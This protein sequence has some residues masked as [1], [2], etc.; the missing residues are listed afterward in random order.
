[1]ADVARAAGVV[2]KP[3]VSKA[4]KTPPP[5]LPFPPPFPPPPQPRG[6]GLG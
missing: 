2:A 5:A 1:M 6:V 3:P 4:G